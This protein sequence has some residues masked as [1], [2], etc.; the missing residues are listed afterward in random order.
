MLVIDGRDGI[1]RELE[2]RNDVIPLVE[3]EGEVYVIVKPLVQQLGVDWSTQYVKLKNVEAFGTV[4]VTLK[5]ERQFRDYTCIPLMR[6]H[7]FLL[8]INWR[9]IPAN[10]LADENGKLFSVR[11]KV[12]I[13][14]E[15]FL[16]VLNECHEGYSKDLQSLIDV[17]QEA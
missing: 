5:L 12:R 14:E 3:V 17:Y 8:S 13:Y 15:L 11:R 6:L 7:D 16:Q 9:K 10:K 4:K 2:F 1:Y